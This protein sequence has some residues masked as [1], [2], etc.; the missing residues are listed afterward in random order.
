MAGLNNRIERIWW[1]RQEP[2]LLLRLVEPL[3][4]AISRRDQKWRA[5]G[6][7]AP[8]LP[9]IS[10]GNITAGGSGKTP[11]VI[12]LADHLR[13]HGY[14]PVILCRG[15][16]GT[17]RAPLLVTADSDPALAGD[18]ACL[19]AQATGCPVIAARDRIAGC[20]LAAAYGDM[21]ILDDGFQYRQLQRRCD[22]VLLPAEGVG[23]G[24][25]IPAGPLREPLQGL[26]RADLI[27]RSGRGDAAPLTG[28]R[29]WRWQARPLA[30]RDAMG[31]GLERPGNVFAVAAIA[32]P[33]RFFNDL[34]TLGLTLEG[35]R[36]YPDHHGYTA[37]E[38]AELAALDAPVVV[39][40]K[41][42]VKLVPLWPSGQPLWVLDQ[43][44]EGEPGLLE[45]ILAKAAGAPT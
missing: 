36:S 38:A 9:L 11:F 25:L 21:L 6:A 37:A 34:Q 44:G 7:V 23:N 45:A 35:R 27:V 13:Q 42:A 24:H 33:E 2:P 20:Q 31:L 43:A 17:S 3:Y 1:R 15:D 12:W 16:G 32:R 8:P 10:V 28:E 39:T 30:L 4:A 14:R 29:E 41:D 18:E 22:I 26:A 19:I 5:A 40:A